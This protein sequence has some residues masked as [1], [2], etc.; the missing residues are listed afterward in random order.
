MEAV[1][2]CL[3]PS[4]VLGSLCFG[5]DASPFPGP[6]KFRCASLCGGY[7][8]QGFTEWGDLGSVFGLD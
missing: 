6:T 4:A 3:P 5:Q 8:E 1:G 2:L 7:N